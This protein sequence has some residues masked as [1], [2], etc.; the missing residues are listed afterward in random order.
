MYV[1]NSD[2]EKIKIKKPI[3]V[4]LYQIKKQKTEKM[5]ESPRK[6]PSY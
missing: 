2:M 1:L 4:I 3:A 5:F 6:R